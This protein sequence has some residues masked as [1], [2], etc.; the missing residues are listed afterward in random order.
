VK[1][2][3]RPP[4]HSGLCRR[5]CSL[6]VGSHRWAVLSGHPDFLIAARQAVSLPVLRK[7]FLY[8]TYQVAEARAWGADCIFIIMAAVDDALAA[9]LLPQRAP[10]AWTR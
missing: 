6:S 2:S 7:D 5:R 4:T 10:T 9:E 8:D 3:I 1:P